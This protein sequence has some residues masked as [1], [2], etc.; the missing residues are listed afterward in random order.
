MFFQ[1]S[2]EAVFVW[3]NEEFED[4]ELF[5]TKENKTCT[6]LHNCSY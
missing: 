6:K 5:F 2:G 4:K 1:L 3:I